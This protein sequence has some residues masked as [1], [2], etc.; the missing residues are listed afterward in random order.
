MSRTCEGEVLFDEVEKE[1]LVKL[2]RNMGRFCGI[3]VLTNRLI[4]HHFHLLVRV[5]DRPVRVRVAS[6]ALWSCGHFGNVARGVV[7]AG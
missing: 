7:L 1:A 5:P 2:I 6:S 3:E 4:G